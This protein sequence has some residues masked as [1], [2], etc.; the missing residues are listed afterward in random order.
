MHAI[1]AAAILIIDFDAQKIG[2]LRLTSA[3]VCMHEPCLRGILCNN[4]RR[5]IKIIFNAQKMG[6]LRRASVTVCAPGL[7]GFPR[8]PM[9]SSLPPYLKSILM[10][11]KWEY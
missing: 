11:R 10:R 6:V 7:S 8:H 9:Q 3:T 2:A 4:R 5:H 1:I